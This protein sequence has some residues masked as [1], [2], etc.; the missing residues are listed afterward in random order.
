MVAFVSMPFGA[1]TLPS[2]GLTLLR[3]GL[4]AA[5]VSASI[6]YFT[7]DFADLIGA[8]LYDEISGSLPE[9]LIGEWVFSEPAFA[10]SNEDDYESLLRTALSARQVDEL[11]PQ[12]M[13]C[14]SYATAFVDRCAKRLVAAKPRIV[15]ITSVF[16]QTVASVALAK[17]LKAFSPSTLVIIGG[18]NCEGAMGVTL[19][20]ETGCFDAVFSGEGDALFVELT[21]YAL[22]KGN[23]P[24]DVPGLTTRSS[25]ASASTPSRGVEDLDALPF[26]DYNDFFE[27]FASHGFAD[28]LNPRI[29]FETSR[30]CWW[31]QKHH[32]TFCGLNGDTMAFR[33]KS[34]DRAMRELDSLTDAHPGREVFVVDNILDIKYFATFLPALAQRENKVKLFYEVK[35]NLSR[36]QLELMKDAGIETIQPGIES[37][38][39]PV[40]RIMRKGISSIQNVQHLK[41]CKE[42]GILPLW[43]IL[44]GFPGEARSNYIETMSL[45]KLI[46]HLQPPT[47]CLRIR[48]DRFSPNFDNAGDLG[49]KDVRPYSAYGVV[50]PFDDASLMDIAYYFTYDY[51]EPHGAI[52]L[53]P[54]LARA[55]KQWQRA[56]SSSELLSIIQG[57]TVNIFDRRV[58][59]ESCSVRLGDVSSA[60]YS[61]CDGIKSV[62]QIADHLAIKFETHFAEAAVLLE[63]EPLIANG[64]VM[65]EGNQVL[66]IG[67]AFGRYQPGAAV[68]NSLLD[69]I[70]TAR[71]GAKDNPSTN[72]D[73]E[74][75]LSC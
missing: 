37:L 53:G 16:Q 42:I 24:N 30:G 54:E 7:L 4:V 44:W 57:D 34:S 40:L 49:F 35:A 50:F 41:W 74:R 55:A 2:I 62:R 33:S 70:R 60:I 1:L 32:C 58:G 48:M 73:P 3:Q 47:N 17:R 27:Q 12:L 36:A 28:R 26:V 6:D 71:T 61:Y 63:L 11:M 65:T 43:N 25:A 9:L 72:A 15:A 68:V 45:M 13:D 21:S 52:A 20:R 5:G 10:R 38:S 18:A 31:G 23:F 39:T 56:H 22:D 67:V 29:L 59:R 19:L 51:A 14:R 75:E 69:D 64:F 46:P 8:E 66:S